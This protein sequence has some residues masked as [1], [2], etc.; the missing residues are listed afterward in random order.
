MGMRNI[1]APIG[2]H[3]VNLIEALRQHLH[4]PAF[5]AR[6]RIRPQDFT[7]KRSLTFPVVMLLILQKTVKSVQ[8]HLHVTGETE[9]R[10]NGRRGMDFLRRGFSSKDSQQTLLPSSPA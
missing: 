7:R 2:Q 6:H 10:Q 1:T 4:D 5:R 8:S 3:L 9:L